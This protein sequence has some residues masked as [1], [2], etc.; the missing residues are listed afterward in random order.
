MGFR[1]PTEG[2]EA[3]KRGVNVDPLLSK[4]A[5]FFSTRS[6]DEGRQVVDAGPGA[7]ELV[8]FKYGDEG[9]VPLEECLCVPEDRLADP[10]FA[11]AIVRFVRASMKGW[12]YAEQN[13][14]RAAEIVLDY[15]APGTRTVPHRRR[16]LGEVAKLTAGS[17][18]A[19]ASADLVRS[20]RRIPAKLSGHM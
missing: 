17:N 3:L 7:D 6:C 10:A 19:L 18:G 14:D 16:R 8:I 1:I 4:Q 15:G 11:D 9:A 20:S 12:T 5:D 13:P 2:V